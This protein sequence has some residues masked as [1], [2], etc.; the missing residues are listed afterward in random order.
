MCQ[1]M[2]GR[3]LN[4]FKSSQVRKV[5]S[6][7]VTKIGRPN[8]TLTDAAERNHANWICRIRTPTILEDGG[9]S[10]LAD[11][12]FTELHQHNRG[13]RICT[14]VLTVNGTNNGVGQ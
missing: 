10:F 6:P 13:L 9:P 11:H 5:V 4:H 3:L 1:G 14:N 12:L 7:K 2:L 8:S